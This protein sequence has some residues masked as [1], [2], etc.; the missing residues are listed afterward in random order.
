MRSS[1]LPPSI[2]SVLSST[3]RLKTSFWTPP[4]TTSAP[5]P[6]L[7]NVFGR[8]AKPVTVSSA[9]VPINLG[10]TH[11]HSLVIGRGHRV[12]Y[13]RWRESAVVAVDALFHGEQGGR[14][15]TFCHLRNSG[16]AA[17]AHLR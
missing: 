16:A 10:M 12:G 9:P 13:D 3:R 14:S 4:E 2:V 5:I 1:P 15:V 6:K 7:S 11:L 17:L 8:L